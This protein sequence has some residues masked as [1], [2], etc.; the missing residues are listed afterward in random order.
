M[1]SALASLHLLT[2]SDTSLGIP[3]YRTAIQAVQEIFGRRHTD[4]HSAFDF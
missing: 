1:A 4:G 3:A 2:C